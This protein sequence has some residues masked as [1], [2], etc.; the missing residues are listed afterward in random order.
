MSTIIRWTDG[1]IVDP[2]MGSGT[3]LVAAAKIGRVSVG[4]ELDPHYFDIAV[5]RVSEAWNQPMLLDQKPSSPLPNLDLFNE[6]KQ[7]I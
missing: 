5:K 4:I 6:S 2:F 7:Q 3:T 1:M